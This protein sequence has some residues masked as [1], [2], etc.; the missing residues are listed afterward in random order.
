MSAR[1]TCGL[2]ARANLGKPV[3]RDRA[4]KFHSLHEV[5]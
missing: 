5:T 4:E 3:K 2:V 1:L